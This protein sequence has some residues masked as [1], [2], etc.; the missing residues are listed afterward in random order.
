MDIRN[1]NSSRMGG[2]R[3]RRADWERDQARLRALREEVFVREQGV[4]LD[5]EW[6]G[7]DA[8]CLHV[9]AES[10]A[11]QAIG[12]GRLLADGHIGR[13]AVQRGWRRR[14]VGAAMLEFL[15]A[16][17]RR[18]GMAEVVLNAQT[19]ALAF[20]ARHGFVPEGPP[21]LEAGIPHQA[22]RLPLRAAPPREA[23]N[24]AV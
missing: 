20:Y 22:M 5:L 11:G 4:P 12:T 17:A 2:Y 18:L 3:I 10:D 9:L 7:L 23:G 8:G 15:L 24:G 13:M 21:F 6:D 19:H 1:Y 14:G 16:E